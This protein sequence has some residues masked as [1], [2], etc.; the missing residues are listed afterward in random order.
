[1]RSLNLD[2][3]KAFVEV[4]ERGSFTAAARELNLTQPDAACGD[5]SWSGASRWPWWSVSASGPT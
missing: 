3:L 1:M 4:V 2:Q 5:A